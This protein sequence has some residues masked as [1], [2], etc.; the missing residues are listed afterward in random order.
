MHCTQC[1][2]PAEGRFCG[3][4][5]ASLAELDC[6]TCSQPIAAGRRF[7]S[8]CGSPVRIATGQGEAPAGASG[9]PDPAWWVAGALLVAL[10]I[11]GGWAVLGSGGPQ[12]PGAPAAMGQP[13]ALGPAPQ[14]DLSQMTPREA[15]DRL[16]DRVMRALTARDTI[17]VLNFLPMAIDAYEIA[18]PLDLDGLFHLSLLQRAALDFEGAL[19]TAEEG[20]ADDPDH[21]L[22]LAAA[23]AAAEE[24]GDDALA[25]RYHRRLLEVWDQERAR[26]DRPE[27][28][29]HEPALPEMR[30]AAERFTGGDG[31]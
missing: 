17:E 16:Y 4:C 15:A 25:E 30:R 27:Y 31:G 11:V 13:G 9:A 14:I 18:R 7:C 22:N 1:G 5:G 24:L 20:L 12:P 28:R 3:G 6:P 21:L 23:A 29:E 19:R 26:E 8:A 10:L 2:D